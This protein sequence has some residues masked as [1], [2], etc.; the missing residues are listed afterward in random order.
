MLE[1]SVELR[2][3]ERNGDVGK[4]AIVAKKNKKQRDKA[5][6]A[7]SSNGNRSKTARRPEV[8]FGFAK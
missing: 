7:G 6:T 2:I 4:E 5:E 1:L 8:E 3:S